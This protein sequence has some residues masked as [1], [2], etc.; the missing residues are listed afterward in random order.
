MTYLIVFAVGGLVCLIGQV[1]INLTKFTSARILVTFLLL[2][3]LLETIGVFKYIKDF[4]QAGITIPI[5]GFGSNLAKGAIEG[6]QQDGL[7]GALVG[8]AE[9][10][11]AG[12]AVAIFVGFVVALFA[13]S[14]TKK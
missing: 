3:V 8:G 10:S 9:A 14:K 5:I 4:A 1:I 11:A 2:G 6:A 13:Q 7:I 12:V